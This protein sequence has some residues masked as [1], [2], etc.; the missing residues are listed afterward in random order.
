MPRC[1]T[2]RLILGDQLNRHHGWFSQTDEDTLYLVCELR[3]ETDYVRHH[4]QKVL[5]FFAAMLAFARELEEAGHRVL[6]L[7]L[8]DTEACAD[9]PEL[10]ERQIDACGARRFEY[11]RPDEYRLV[12]QLEKFCDGLEIESQCVDT[13]HFLLP[14]AEIADCFPT[15]KN[16]RME[17]FY[18]QMRRRLDVLMDADGE[19]E[20]GKWNY[21]Q[22]NREPWSADVELPAPLRF[23]NDVSG[24]LQRMRRHD[25]ETMG[26]I[27]AEQLCWPIDRAQALEALEH[28]VD[29]ALPTFGPYQ[30]AMARDNWHLSHSLLSFAL[31]SKILS[32]AEVIDAVEAAWRERPDEFGL[33]SVEGFI[34]Q[35]LG[36]REFMRGIYWSRMPAYAENN[37]LGHDRDLPG[38]FWTGD[39]DMACMAHSL[40]QSLERAYAHHIQRLMVIG[41]FCLMAG[42]DPDQVDAWYLGVYI[43]AVEWV[44]MPNVRGMS[45]YA[46][47]GV[48]ASKPYAASANYIKKMSDYCDGCHYAAGKRSGEGSCPFNSLYWHFMQRNR[49]ELSK[50][51]RIAM[52]FGNWDRMKD[53][54]REATLETAET[55]LDTLDTL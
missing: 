26:E 20:G 49:E 22:E 25:I 7:D 27:E 36:W 48:V 40:G 35:I 1:R 51:P 55:Y 28:F 30:D 38:F 18:R 29:S 24:L 4:V 8:D 47:G 34:R 12:Q 50:N 2:L 11:Q 9:L 41:N 32:P 43:D 54:T 15:D 31:N 52:L 23:Q 5:A 53:E 46:D 44:E 21:D 10:L 45:Q 39:T 19:P 33:A 14:F 16:Q 3:Q 17:T 37:H 13:E 42:I 6:H